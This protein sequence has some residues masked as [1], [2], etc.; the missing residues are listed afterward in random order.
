MSLELWLW[1]PASRVQVQRRR[2]TVEAGSAGLSLRVT[3]RVTLHLR[4]SVS[5]LCIIQESALCPHAPL[6][7]LSVRLSE[8]TLLLR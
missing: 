4:A 8:R 3:R 5:S 2:P 7:E 1:I 6:T